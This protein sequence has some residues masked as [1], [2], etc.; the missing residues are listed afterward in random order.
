M[1]F[2]PKC[3]HEVSHSLIT[4]IL[5][6]GLWGW[7]AGA[8]TNSWTNSVSGYWEGSDW[9][10]GELPGA[11]QTVLF[12][13]AGWK[14]LAI[15]T[16]TT[17]SF[18]QSLHIFSLTLSSPTNSFNELLMNY[19][20][21]HVP[22]VIGD[23]NFT[24]TLIVESNAAVDMLSSAL[25]VLNTPL[26]GPS[27]GAFSIGGT[28]MESDGSQVAASVMQV[29][30][31]GPGV[32]DLTNS[33]L[34]V[35]NDEYIGGNFPATFN[36]QGGT[37]TTGNLVLQAGGE[38]DL[39]AGYFDGEIEFQG[40]NFNQWGGA[41]ASDLQY[42]FWLGNYHLAG[43]ILSSGDLAI[44]G[45]PPENLPRAAGGLLLQTG[46]TN[47]AGSIDL[48]NSYGTGGYTLTNGVLTAS[49][50][51]VGYYTSPD[52]SIFGCVFSQSGGFHTNGGIGVY[53]SYNRNFNIT[54]SSY[55]LS[56][57]TLQTPS[58]EL[59]MGLLTQSGGTNEVGELSLDNVS[60]YGLSGGWLIAQDIHVNGGD[61]FGQ[62]G[63]FT[64]SGGA[65]QAGNLSLNSSSSYVFTGG[66][67]TAGAIQV[68]ESSVFHHTGGMVNL[69]G[70]LTLDNG[71]W[72]EQ[73]GGQTFG[74]LQVSGGSGSTI[75]LPTSSCA[76][77]FAD[78]S[79]LTW[80][81][82]ALLIVENWNGSLFGGGQQQIIFGHSAGALTATQI[83]LVQFHNPAGLGAGSYP[84]KILS[85]GEIVPVSA[86]P[87]L[88][89]SGSPSGGV[90]LTLQGHSGL[91]Y[92]IDVSSDLIH[93]TNWTNQSAAN[94]SISFTDT[95]AT[96]VTA[97]FY[98][99]IQL[100]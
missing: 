78:S 17:Q 11:S 23:S 99:A 18:P 95:G 53:G 31:I 47:F 79:A 26:N 12:T 80:S 60:S 25:V 67:L 92:E 48:G 8:Q 75:L 96:N 19:A 24:G 21:L 45:I 13:N 91:T 85:S 94:G 97:R 64:Q 98:R 100:P 83:S 89:I 52:T 9:S 93:W 88:A 2:L 66:Q 76:L 61:L 3:K 39:Y 30:D 63:A 81:S 29:G 14:A 33:I 74:P 82:N 55:V 59:N 27:P 56:G 16:N 43:G 90:Q 71:T 42:Q 6:G 10:L 54:L 34:S 87:L 37:N 20:G 86:A 32:Y 69:P 41:V 51:S 46:G 58:I 28:F 65:N 15:G 57:G 70:L 84:A 1:I 40:G 77:Q 68:N 38:Y 7:D 62:T 35:Q 49:N 22:L 72:D 44:P 4:L 36:Q 73:T 50:L 5:L